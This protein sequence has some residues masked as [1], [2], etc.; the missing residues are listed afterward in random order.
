M[1]VNFGPF[2]P[3]LPASGTHLTRCE[4]AYP[5]G[6]G[7]YRP[8][9]SF[10]SASSALPATF[11]GGSSFVASDGTASLLAGTTSTLSRLSAGGW[12]NAQSS[13]SVNERWKFVQF[14][15]FAVAVNGDTTY[16]VNL[17]SQAASAIPAAPSL[18]DVWV[19]GDY[20]MGAQPNGNKLKVRWSAFN[21]HTNWTIGSNQA[22]EQTML[23]GGEVMGGVGGEFG[24]I[25]QRNRLV[26]VDRTG[27]SNAPF[28]F[29]AISENFGCAA[30]A[31]IAAAGR[32]VFFFSDRG[33]VALEDGQAIRQIGNEK[34][35]Q[36]F[37]D[38]IGADDLERM[39]SAVDPQRSVVLW[40]IPGGLIW[41]YN[42]ALDR[43][44]TL[45]LPIEG[46]FAGFENS[47]TLEQLA[48]DVPDLD[49]ATISFDDPRYSG[50]APRF[51]VVQ[52]GQVGTMTGPNLPALIEMEDIEPNQG[53]RTR[54]R[55]VWPDIDADAGVTVT[56]RQRQRRGDAGMDKVGSN[57][58]ASGRIALEANGRYFDMKVEIDDPDWT[59]AQ[60]IELEQSAGAIR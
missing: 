44:F 34:F 21:N 40:G 48:V 55:A 9:G 28:A 31:S 4:N 13:L 25:L 19:V 37:R 20:V 16:E 23:A 59:Y 50:G 2:L 36:S 60:G 49:A 10:Q 11:L 15:D 27:D 41:G 6:N 5:S 32:T 58:Q 8:A 54:V 42:W 14:G 45:N 1:Q 3:D 51:Y 12:I 7:L 22:G 29:D 30:K 57:L 35:D 52:N 26:R 24:V 17:L 56:L 46:L 39:Y 53:R 38:A 18:I 33:F 43:A 47:I